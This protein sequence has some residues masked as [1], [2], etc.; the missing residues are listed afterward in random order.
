MLRA[1]FFVLVLANV[2]YFAWTRGALAAFGTEPAG[3]TER[4]PQRM[5]QQVRPQAVQIKPASQ[6]SS[7]S[8][9]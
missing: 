3:M 9:R 7:Q 8:A 2:V 6:A 4:E 5:A 1:V